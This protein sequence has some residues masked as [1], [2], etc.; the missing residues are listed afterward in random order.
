MNHAEHL[1]TL[2]IKNLNDKRLDVITTLPNLQRLVLK[3]VRAETAF[4]LIYVV[5]LPKRT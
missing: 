5:D 1:K 3:R 2:F 4:A